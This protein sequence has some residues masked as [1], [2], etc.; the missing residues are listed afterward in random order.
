MKKKITI[1]VP[2]DFSTASRAGMRFAIQWARQ[3]DAKLVFAHV[4]SILR[5]TSWTYKQFE[6][7]Q[8]AERTLYSRRLR[9]MAKEVLHSR[10]IARQDYS[11]EVLEGVG[12][13]IT[14]NERSRDRPEI[15][16]IC[17]ATR[18]AGKIKKLFGTHTGNVIL[19]SEIPV[20]AVPANYRT[21]PIKRVLY[22]TDLAECE[23]EL[24]K[25][26]QITR[27]LKADLMVIHFLEP[28][29]TR[30]DPALLN[31]VWEK[32]YGYSIQLRFERADPDLSLAEN[33]QKAIR[34]VKPSLVAMFTDRRRTLFQ[35][36]FYPSQ[37]ERLSFDLTVPLLV[38]TKKV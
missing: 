29:G 27:A 26:V 11:T 22:A 19:H 15:D 3:Q 25:I 13:D 31:K 10:H 7:F 35:R 1:L 8:A 23:E 17:M 20:V 21:K 33:L 37:A 14:L 28:G 36:L 16:L 24:G 5:M 30:L 18:G 12:P 32:E 38:L 2:T 4:L 6:A 9:K 34:R